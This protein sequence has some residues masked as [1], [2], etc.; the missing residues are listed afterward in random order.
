MTLFAAT[1][2]VHFITPYIIFLAM[3]FRKKTTTIIQKYPQRTYDIVTI[4]LGI[5]IIP[6]YTFVF[7]LPFDASPPDLLLG[8]SLGGGLPLGLWLLN[9][10]ALKLHWRRNIN[11]D[12]LILLP[13]CAIVE[14]II[15]RLFLPYFLTT[16]VSLNFYLAILLSSVGF[17]FLHWP[18]RGFRGLPYICLFTL[19]T[20]LVYLKFGLVS[21]CLFHVIHNMILIFFTPTRRIK[22][23]SPD[24]IY[25]SED[26]W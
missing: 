12:S 18:I 1:F 16:F 22:K 19:V 21:A 15:W 11:I 9:G 4:I 13:M 7:P 20:V 25:K 3:K 24:V 14:E 5:G 8:A 17:I 10:K 6:L 23:I 2:I 26:N